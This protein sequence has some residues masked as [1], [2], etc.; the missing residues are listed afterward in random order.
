MAKYQSTKTFHDL[1]CAHRQWRHPGHCRFIHGYSRSF[2]FW[3][4]CHE[5]TDQQFVVDF[6]DLKDLRA[7]LEHMFD[8][9]M[10]I[11]SDDP[12]RATFEALHARG[13]CDLRVLPNCGMEGTSKYV[14]AYAD[15]LLREKTRGRAWVVRV[16]TR[17]NAKNSASYED[18]VSLEDEAGGAVDHGIGDG[19][20]RQ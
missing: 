1:P 4:E 12:E 5:L 19:C 14:H 16:E 10:L 13:V 11:N 9:T 17:E 8:H 3:F 2:T 20:G 6:G 7:W 15:R 18:L